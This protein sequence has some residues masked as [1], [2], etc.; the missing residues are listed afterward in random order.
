MVRRDQGSPGENR[1]ERARAAEI[2]C[3]A[4][5]EKIAVLT[6]M[7]RPRESSSGPPLLPGLIAASVCTQPLMGLPPTPSTSRPSA[8]TTPV[9]SAV[10]MW[11]PNA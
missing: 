6:P 10:P 11:G 4:P 7:S 5:G 2:T 1:R 9:V 8:E 3:E